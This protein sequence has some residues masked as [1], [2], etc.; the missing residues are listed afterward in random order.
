MD[1][2]SMMGSAMAGGLGGPSSAQ[3]GNVSG[4]QTST[5]GD[6]VVG[7]GANK[8]SPTSSASWITAAASVAGLAV[9]IYIAYKAYKK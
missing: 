9:T 4:N 2:Y 6:F 8:E 1:P 7:S 5:F 3:S